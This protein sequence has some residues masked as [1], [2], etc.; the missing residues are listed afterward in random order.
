MQKAS[1]RA[2]NPN[3]PLLLLSRPMPAATRPTALSGDRPHLQRCHQDPTS[4]NPRST[5][6]QTPVNKHPPSVSSDNKK[7]RRRKHYRELLPAFPNFFS[8][9]FFLR[10]I[11]F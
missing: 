8:F 4:T 2:Q 1:G 7:R 9:F 10:F 6:E 11:Y 5:S 3:P